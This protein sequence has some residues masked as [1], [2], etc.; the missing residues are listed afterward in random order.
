[1]MMRD[2]KKSELQC[3][4]TVDRRQEEHSASLTPAIHKSVSTD[5]FMTTIE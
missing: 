5:V 1:M 2:R 4:N 3:F